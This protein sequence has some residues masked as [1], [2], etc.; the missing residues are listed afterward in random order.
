MTAQP[1][2]LVVGGTGRTGRLLVVALLARGARVRAIVRSAAR[3][4]PEL[5]PRPGLELVEA[6]LLSLPH[7]AL[8]AQLRG[9]DAACSCLGH[10][11]TLRGVLGPPHDLVRQAVAR[12][13]RAAEAL[14]PATPIRLVLMSSV[15]VHRPGPVDARRGAGERAFL[16][17]LRALL[18][19]ARDNQRAADFLLEQVGPAHP[20]VAWAVVRPDTLLPGSVSPYAVH[21]GLVNAVFKPGQSRMANVADFMAELAMG[22]AAWE[23]WRGRL[24]VIVDRAQAAPLPP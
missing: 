22:G 5:A 16:W 7:E 24:P 10:T 12:L 23:A 6:D 15:S 14:R 3:V 2:V 9:C 17:L 18:P 13:C 21:E 8:V 11:L 4:P 1:T 20:W 19:P